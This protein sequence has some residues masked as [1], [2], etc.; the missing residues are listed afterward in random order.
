MLGNWDEMDKYLETH[1]LPILTQ[2]E[3]ENLNGPIISEEIKLVIKKLSTK[4]SSELIASLEF[5]QMCKEEL[6]PIPLKPF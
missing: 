2:E 3:T 5:Y 6:I 4:K 1:K